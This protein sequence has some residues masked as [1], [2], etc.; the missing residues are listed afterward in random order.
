MKN[1]D[2]GKVVQVK[3]HVFHDSKPTIEVSSSFLYHNCFSNFENTFETINE[4][5]YVI[6]LLDTATIGVIES[7][8]WLAWE[9]DSQP[10]DRKSVV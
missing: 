5:D 9:D 3:G 1:T 4:P 8:E 2:A 6:E 7:K 10:I